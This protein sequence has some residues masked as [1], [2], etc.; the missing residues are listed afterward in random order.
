MLLVL[1]AAEIVVARSTGS[2]GAAGAG[3]PG[4]RGR[5]SPSFRG[6]GGEAA[7]VDLWAMSGEP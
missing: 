6:S 3:G 7:T 1:M 2:S 5:S 4:R